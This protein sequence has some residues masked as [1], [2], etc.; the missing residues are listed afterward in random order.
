MNIPLIVQ[1][2]L[3]RVKEEQII[4]ICAFEKDIELIDELVKILIIEKKNLFFVPINS[5]QA[6]QLSDLG[7][8][9]ISLNDR[10][11]DVAIEFVDGVDQY[12]NFFK[13]KTTSF[14]RDKMI[15]QSAL[16]LI[17]VVNNHNFKEE[18][19]S[20]IYVEISSFAWQRTISNL[21]SYGLARIVSDV[22]GNFFK[23]EMGHYLAR[24]TIDKNIILEDFEYSVRNIP[25]VLET[26]LFLGLADTIFVYF[27]E[28][29]RLEIKTRAK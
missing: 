14:I 27:E 21:Q 17:V 26:G 3:K 28:E 25:G 19:D 1:E 5:R 2:L 22:D 13:K 24:I 20:D 7:Q 9:T 6:K 12:Y 8:K 16:N 23:T 18:I 10:E 29:N 15:S 4:S 11:I